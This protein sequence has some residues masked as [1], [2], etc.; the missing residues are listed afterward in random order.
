MAAPTATSSLP[1]VLGAALTVYNF[2]SD[3][4]KANKQVPQQV[5]NLSTLCKSIHGVCQSLTNV[6][7]EISGALNAMLDEIQNA[8][9]LVQKLEEKNKKWYF[10]PEKILKALDQHHESLKE[11]LEV[12]SSVKDTAAP[13]KFNA[14]NHIQDAKA[15]AFWTKH[16]GG[17]AFSVPYLKFADA[18][19]REYKIPSTKLAPSKP[20]LVMDVYVFNNETRSASLDKVVEL[21]MTYGNNPFEPA[22][23]KAQTVAASAPAITAPAGAGGSPTLLASTKYFFI[24]TD[25][26]GGLVLEIQDG[27]NQPAALLL[28]GK[29]NGGAHQMW[30]VNKFGTTVNRLSGLCIDA[31]KGVAAGNHL[32]QWPTIGGPNQRWWLVSDGSLQITEAPGMCADISTKNPVGDKF[33]LFLWNWNNTENQR[34]RFCHEMIQ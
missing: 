5:K 1:N 26:K 20:D 33:R 8:W 28:A 23:T 24:V 3:W 19:S 21:I 17:E 4:I 16:F 30:K 15:K 7:P 13:A 32:Q 9:R 22:I 10:N 27:S 18:I 12:L 6:T 29:Y 11:Y 31:D 2:I 14:A 34:F 25:F